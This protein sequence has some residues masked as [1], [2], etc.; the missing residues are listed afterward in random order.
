VYARALLAAEPVRLRALLVRIH[1]GSSEPRVPARGVVTM[2]P[3][4]DVPL[5][6][7]LAIGF[8]PLGPRVIR[9]DLVERAL[10]RLRTEE[11][12][13]ELPLEIGRWLGVKAAELPRVLAPLGYRPRGAAW[14]RVAPP[15]SR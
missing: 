6:S 9:V 11:S 14:E 3:A 10:A 7:Y 4:R 13:F 15:P 5:E 1:R 2:A 12:P 8:L